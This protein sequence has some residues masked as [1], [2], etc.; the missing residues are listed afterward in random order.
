MNIEKNRLAVEKRI[1]KTLTDNQFS[2]YL[3]HGYVITQDYL[4]HDST[5]LSYFRTYIT[6]GC[7]GTSSEGPISELEAKLFNSL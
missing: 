4:Y 3:I 2:Y 5:E 1:N 6:E 7:T